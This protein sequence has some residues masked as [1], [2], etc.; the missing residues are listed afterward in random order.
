MTKRKRALPHVLRHGEQ[1]SAGLDE[2]IEQSREGI[3]LAKEVSADDNPWAIL[4]QLTSRLADIADV[5]HAARNELH[6]IEG[7][8]PVIDFDF[9]RRTKVS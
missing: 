6:Q 3:A 2:I 7:M 1:A 8:D 9:R 4:A 5:A